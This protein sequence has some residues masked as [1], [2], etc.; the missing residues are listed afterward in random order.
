MAQYGSTHLL[1]MKTIRGHSFLRFVFQRQPNHHKFISLL[2]GMECH[3]VG[4]YVNPNAEMT[5]DMNLP[6]VGRL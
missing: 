2:T 6:S 3:F 4:S 5:H 1:I